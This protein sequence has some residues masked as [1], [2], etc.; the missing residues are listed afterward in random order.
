LEEEEHAVRP[1]RRAAGIVL[2]IGALAV[3][4]VALALLLRMP[5]TAAL[6]QAGHLGLASAQVALALGDATAPAP[7]RAT[8]PAPGDATAPPTRRQDT[9]QQQF[10]LALGSLVV[11]FALLLAWPVLGLWRQRQRV[12]ASL[13]QF[14]SGLGSG[15]WHDAVRTLREERLGAPSAF[16]ALASGVEGV[17]GESERRWKALAELSADWYWETDERHAMSW[18]SGSAPVLTVQGWQASEVI[19]RRRDQISACEPPAEGWEHFHQRLER[20]EAFRDLEFRVTDRQRRHHIWV[21]ISGRPRLDAEGRF[22]GYEGVGRDVTERRAAHER[23]VASEQRWSLMAGLASDWYWQTDAEHRLLPLAPELLRRFGER[24]DRFV[25]L[26]RWDAYRDALTPEQ[27]AEHRADLEAR[28]P[29]RSLQF[30]VELAPAQLV[31]LSIS[32]L[33]R[34]DGSGRF[35]GYHGVGRDITVRKQAERLLASAQS[36]GCAAG[37][38]A[39]R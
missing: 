8:A 23:L 1:G 4:G 22:R 2:R 38:R 24:A 13:Q 20:H 11:V 31:W 27:W 7:G 10:E 17:L 33:P 39:T 29:F 19:G 32:G 5:G 28:Q 18:L 35:L 6:H 15:D 34:F 25:G 12:R 37:R 26:T 21:S 16:D 30:E 9:R 3:A 36:T 14:S